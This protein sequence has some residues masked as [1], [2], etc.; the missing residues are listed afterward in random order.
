MSDKVQTPVP[1]NSASKGAPDG[2]SDAPCVN[3]GANVHGRSE[4]GES[5]RGSYPNPHAGKTETNTGFMAHG[6]QTNIAYYGDG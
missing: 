5:G 2:A 6:G 1:G 4:G 3:H